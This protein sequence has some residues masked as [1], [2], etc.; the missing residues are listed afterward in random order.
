MR[1]RKYKGECI[2][3]GMHRQFNAYRHD[4]E[5]Y[6]LCYVQ[7][8]NAIYEIN[9]YYIEYNTQIAD[10]FLNYC[11]ELVKAKD[12]DIFAIQ[13]MS[14][15]ELFEKFYKKK[16]KNFEIP[17]NATNKAQEKRDL[18][19]NKFK[20]SKMIDLIDWVKNN[21]DKKGDEIQQLAEHIFNK[22]YA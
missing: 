11:K 4:Y 10:E 2:V 20:E 16:K 13:R 17:N 15:K 7:A 14:E 12:S 6:A 21:T 1:G 22:R 9:P 5:I 19:F 8:T 18:K 3:F